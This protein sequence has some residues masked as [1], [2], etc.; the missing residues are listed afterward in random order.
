MTRFD[1]GERLTAVVS[2]SVSNDRE[3]VGQ[4]AETPGEKR[5]EQRRLRVCR[6]Y[7]NTSDATLFPQ[8]TRSGRCV[9]ETS[10]ILGSGKCPM[11]AYLARPVLLF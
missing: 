5:L 11:M 2:S 9:T 4:R 8:E 10:E 3:A 1:G 6:R 7:I